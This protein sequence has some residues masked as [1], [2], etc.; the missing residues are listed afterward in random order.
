LRSSNSFLDRLARQR[1]LIIN[2]R[3][4]VFGIVLLNIAYAIDPNRAMSQY[5]RDRWGADQGFPR[6][7][8]YAIAQ[9]PDGYLWIGT[10]AGLLRFDGWSFRLIKDES[11]SFTIAGVLGLAAAKDGSLW[12][13]LQ[14]L[15]MLR[16]RDGVFENPSSDIEAAMDISAMSTTDRGEVL[17]WRMEKGAF[18]FRGSAPQKFASARDLPRS[19][20]TAI[21][22]TPDGVIWAG[23]RDAGLF[24]LGSGKTSAIRNGLPDLKVNCLLAGGDRDLWVGTDNG[25]VKWNGA[26][27]TSSGLPALNHFQA[28]S[29]V[30]DHD[31][32]LWV[33]T[34]S[35]GLLRFNAQGVAFLNENDS[36]AV[37]ALFEDREGNLWIGSASGLERLRDS[38]FV[39]YSLPEGLPTDGSDPVFVD[40]QN[41]MWFP[42]TDGGLMW[43]KDGNHGQV[44]AAGLDK[45]VVYAMAGSDSEL[46]LGRRR[47]GLTQLR[48]ERDSFSAKTFT[49]ADGLAQDSIYSVYQTRGGTVWAGTLSGG[50]S[51]LSNGTFTNYTTANGL[52]SNTV[53]SILETSGGTMWFA[54]PTGLSALA[55]NHWQTYT[56][57]DGLPSN[58]VDCVLEDSAGMLWIGT[59][60]G[61]AFWG[62]NHFEAP[63]GVPAALRERV[64]GL[65][66]DKF[67]SIW[68]ATSNHVL[69]VNRDKLLH[70]TLAD[71][72][73]REYGPADG[74]RGVEGVKRHR[75]VVTDSLGRIWFS[76][77]KG[78]SVVDPARLRTN[79]T[80]AIVHIQAITADGKPISLLGAIHIPGGRQRITFEYAGLS[81]TVPERVRHRYQLEGFDRG[82]SEP[83][84]TREAVYTNLPPS[85][86]RFRVIASNPDGVWSSN[87]SSIRFEVEPLFW[88]TWWFRL[89]IVLACALGIPAVYRLRLRELTRR[90]N[91]RFEERLAERTRIAQE[92]HDTL[93]QGFL[94]ASMQLHV[95]LDRLPPESPAKTSLGRVLLLMGQVIEEGRNAVQG[96]R[97]SDSISLNLEQ[98]FARVQAELELQEDVG[99]RVIVN[100]QPRPLHPVLRDEI[101]RIGREALVNAFRHSQ[102]KSIEIELQYA[103]RQLRIS[104]RDNGC[105]IDPLLLHSGRDGHW[106]LPGM[107][108]RAG[109]IGAKLHVWSRST[110]GTEVELSVPGHIAFKSQTSRR[111]GWFSRLTSRKPTEAPP[112]LKNETSM[113]GSEE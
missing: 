2:L 5:V 23:T 10:E 20:V 35:R 27:L 29:M 34:D 72:D 76:L 45:D 112:V 25:I 62:P 93:L 39:T 81:L 9:T 58:D 68:M 109:R 48:A 30:R 71:G 87:E 88:Q 73:V 108:E 67:G 65:A 99:F 44:H 69:R 53:V 105:G 82:W 94:S 14:D 113:T 55:G 74:L 1:W 11:G 42:P 79:S 21:A 51:K 16:Y 80:P 52:A 110:G 24:R 100:G 32:N 28:L 97:S 17:A 49:Q 77:N 64:L 86:Y 26:E 66:E 98:A 83:A 95:A 106:G 102:A 92:L 60:A 15:T 43:M 18:G 78:I 40:A 85:S 56:A 50:V 3:A 8:V 19:P 7:P 54:T 57:K 4:F 75:S 59:A 36:E 104:V 63:A 6:G 13:R 89:C 12:I 22:R 91:L 47:G 101:Y 90:L 103:S 111:P 31:A 96:L 70:G 46:W 38:A 37:T 107:R 84:A 61:I 33:G 41:R